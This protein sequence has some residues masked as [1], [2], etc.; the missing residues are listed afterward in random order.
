MTDARTL[1][2]WVGSRYPFPDA[3]FVEFERSRHLRLKHRRILE[4]ALIGSSLM[5]ALLLVCAS[6]L[7]TA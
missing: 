7:P 3:A 1:I 2:E 6:R 5:I 4:L